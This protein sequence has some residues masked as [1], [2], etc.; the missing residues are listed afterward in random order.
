LLPP[1]PPSSVPSVPKN[2]QNFGTIGGVIGGDGLLYEQLDIP[3]SYQGKSGTFEFM[4][5]TK[6]EINHRVFKPTKGWLHG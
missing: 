5:D 3:G 6:G 1:V 2:W 4:K